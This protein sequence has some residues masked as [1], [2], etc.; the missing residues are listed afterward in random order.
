MNELIDY[1]QN[2]L[3]NGTEFEKY[4][5]LLFALQLPS[6]C[7]R[8]EFPQTPDNTGS[9]Q[10]NKD[11]LYNTKG[12]PFDKNLYFAWLNRHRVYFSSWYITI[13][14]FDILCEAIYSLRCQITHT[15]SIRDLSTNVILVESGDMVLASGEILF[16]SISQFCLKMFDAA[17]DT[18]SLFSP[19]ALRAYQI[20]SNMYTLSAKEAEDIGRL[21]DTEY[22]DFWTSRESDLKLYQDYCFYLLG[23]LGSV[24]K[25]LAESSS[26]TVGG[27]TR[28]E[29]EQLVK[30]VEE[31]NVFGDKLN[32]QIRDKYFRRA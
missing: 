2:N 14:P 5:A 23:S 22:K 20:S 25:K 31:C 13:M 15:G 19:Y 7:S 12:K 28:N 6:I 3:I 29:S 21:L 9:N 4:A 17:R 11:V 8:V 18:F 30:V 26:Y 24:K 16:I 27:L 1:M 32:D 10:Y